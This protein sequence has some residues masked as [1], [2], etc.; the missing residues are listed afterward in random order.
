MNYGD[1]LYPIGAGFLAG[2]FVF[3]ISTITGR[4]RNFGIDLDLAVLIGTVTAFGVLAARRP[5]LAMWSI[6]GY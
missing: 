6:P 2:M 3:A 1:V 4:E 5:D